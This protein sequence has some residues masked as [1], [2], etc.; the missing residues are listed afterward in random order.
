MGDTQGTNSQ[1]DDGLHGQLD[2]T[3]NAALFLY[4]GFA[5]IYNFSGIIISPAPVFFIYISLAMLLPTL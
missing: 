4:V 2:Y 5:I 3:I 1:Y